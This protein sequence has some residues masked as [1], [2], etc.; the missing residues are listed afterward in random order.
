MV[1]KAAMAER[2]EVAQQNESLKADLA[3]KG[4]IFN[5]VNPVPFRDA[6]TKSGFYK[7]W[8]GK[9]GNEAWAILE[10]STGELA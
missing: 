6:L 3:G 7:E 10:E 4:L 1:N 5:D 8:R 2:E 9:F